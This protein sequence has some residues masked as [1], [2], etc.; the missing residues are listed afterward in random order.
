MKIQEVEQQQRIQGDRI[1]EAEKLA[2]RGNAQSLKIE[3]DRMES[4]NK[5]KAKFVKQQQALNSLMIISETA[6][7][8]AKA[9][10]E[11]GAAAYVTIAAALIALAAGL[12]QARAMSAQAGYYEGGY[13]GDGNRREV[14]GVTH[15]GEMVMNHKTTSKYRD[16]LEGVHE[17]RINLNEWR[18]KVNMFEA[19][20]NGKLFTLTAPLSVNNNPNVTNV[21]KLESLEKR[22]DTLTNVVRGNTVGFNID[23]NGF[24]RYVSNTYGRYDK[25]KKATRLVA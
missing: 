8:V 2:E 23:E 6:V 25:L 24:S 14:A 18:D 21:I 13:T 17:G 3:K 7:A 16:V 4:L 12:A 11:G 20:T 15:K 10:A 9:A 1:K 22:I 19:L 5:E